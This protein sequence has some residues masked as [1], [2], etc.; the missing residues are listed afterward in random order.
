M[1]PFR[2]V[3][4]GTKES[5]FNKQHSIGRN[6]IERAFGV[7]KARFRCIL[8]ARQLHYSPQKATQ[9]TN[10][11]VAL[12]NICMYYKVQFH[13]ELNSLPTDS[14]LFE[15]AEEEYA[16]SVSNVA[17]ILRNKIANCL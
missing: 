15:L 8:G 3:T 5:K 12:H 16:E 14:N 6:I 1:T 11:C 17:V 2:A 9:I 7:L 10:I 13:D 4:E